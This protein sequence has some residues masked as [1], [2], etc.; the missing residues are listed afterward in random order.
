MTPQDMELMLAHL[1]RQKGRASESGAGL[2]DT[3]VMLMQ[4]ELGR[5]LRAADS[6]AAMMRAPLEASGGDILK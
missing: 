3:L 1:D 4:A 5:D 2:E 6:Q